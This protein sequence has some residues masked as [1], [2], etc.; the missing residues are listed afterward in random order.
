MQ[1]GVAE[2]RIKRQDLP[3]ETQIGFS[4]FGEDALI[5][6]ALQGRGRLDSGFY[7]DVGAFDPVRFSNTA[8]LHLFRGWRGV[9]IDASAATIEAFNQQRPH[10]FNIHAAVSDVEEEVTFFEFN[11]GLMNTIDPKQAENYER[12]QKQSFKVQ[13]EIRM[14]TR[15]L[16]EIIA[17]LPEIPEHIGLLS[18]DCEGVDYR[19]LTSFDWERFKPTVVAVESHKFKLRNVAADPSYAFLIGKGYQLVS[20]AYVTS[21]YAIG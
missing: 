16:D 2:T 18:I 7:V 4:Q 17:S 13:R 9:N 8:L 6:A 20:H 1:L 12:S 5:S 10:D 21:I 14:R 11:Q 19:V 15:R 3:R